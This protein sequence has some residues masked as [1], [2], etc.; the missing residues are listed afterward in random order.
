MIENTVEVYSEGVSGC[1]DR[2]ERRL[3]QEQPILEKQWVED[4]KRFMLHVNRLKRSIEK[5]SAPREEAASKRTDQAS[6]Q[7]RLYKRA[8]E[9]LRAFQAEVMRE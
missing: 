4:S 3:A 1:V 9:S 7:L 6:Q 8:S 5:F 2:I